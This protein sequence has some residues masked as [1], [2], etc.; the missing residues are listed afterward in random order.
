[1]ATASKISKNP[2]GS[3]N[4]NTSNTGNPGSTGKTVPSAETGAAPPMLKPG[5]Q[6]PGSRG[7]KRTPEQYRAEYESLPVGFG[8]P[9]S[10]GHEL[11]EKLR[12]LATDLN[13]NPQTLL[14]FAAKKL[15]LDPPTREEIAVE[16][17]SAAGG[18]SAAGFIVLFKT[19][20]G[21]PLN[22]GGRV[23]GFQITEVARR[24]DALT[25]GEGRHF[26]RYQ[27]D[28]PKSRTRALAAAIRTARQDAKMVGLDADQEGVVT[29]KELPQ[30][31]T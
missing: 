10:P 5:P 28:D 6:G 15:L 11:L 1:M 23:I 29:V 17:G 7:G 21:K 20:D 4:A 13:T 22:A 16:M 25:L 26:A 9:G 31:S 14:K 8:I 19:K 27:P 18:G 24:R 30:S 2:V 12:T 3:A